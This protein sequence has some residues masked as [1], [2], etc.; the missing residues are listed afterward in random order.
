MD[1]DHALFS[2]MLHLNNN[3]VSVV[4]YS[5]ELKDQWDDFVFNSKNGIF[6]FYRDYLEY[7][8]D[9]FLDH[10]LV[11]IKNKKIVG[12]LP[13]NM[14]KNTLYSHEGLTFGGII[15]GFNMKTLLMLEIFDKLIQYCQSMEIMEIEYKAIPSIYHSVPAEEDLYALFRLN[16]KLIGRNVSST[17]FLPKKTIYDHDKKNS[18]EKGKKNNL[19]VKRSDDLN[20]FMEIAREVVKTRHG[21]KLAHKTEEIESLAKRFP[22]NIKLFA[23]YREEVMLAGVVV[24]ESANVAHAQ[25]AANSKE[26]R[27]IGAEDIIFDY[28]I[29]DYYKEKKYFDFGISTEKLG[30][31]LNAGLIGYK[32]DFGARAIMHDLYK[33]SPL[34]IGAR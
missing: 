18:I 5:A 24:Y 22:D 15:S 21:V 4:K 23:S 19:V 2:N 34:T 30:Q 25:Y 17:I 28:L 3:S 12:L 32:E 11:F 6:L 9:R 14:K 26:G 1:S 8:S 29:N 33:I 31:E 20:Q 10:S 13:A 7:H 16:A 27:T